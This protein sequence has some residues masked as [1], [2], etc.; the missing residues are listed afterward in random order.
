MMTRLHS[1]KTSLVNA[2]HSTFITLQPD[3]IHAA[4]VAEYER[5][6]PAQPAWM[7]GPVDDRRESE[8]DSDDVANSDTC[9]DDDE[10]R[11]PRNE[12]IDGEA[13][14]GSEIDYDDDEDHDDD[15][16]INQTTNHND[17]GP[18]VCI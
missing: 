7:T 2:Q 13:L 1:T 16:T 10:R 3:G 18:I 15:E 11:M 8:L 4:T 9:S 12:F 14:E 6:A 17:V 5:N